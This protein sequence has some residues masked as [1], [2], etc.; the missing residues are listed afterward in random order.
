MGKDYPLGMGR[1]SLGVNWVLHNG[2]A[3][4]P[5]RV[6]LNPPYSHPLIEQFA[7]KLLAQIDAGYVSEAMVLVNNNTETAWWHNLADRADLLFA[8]R[9]RVFFH[10][11]GQA[12]STSP[13]QGQ[14]L[15]YF[16][17]NTAAFHD[18]FAAKGIVFSRF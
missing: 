3:M 8:F 18:I 4:K 12:E 5:A 10:R 2:P 14:T 16:G 15:F 13:R 9:S 17:P 6:W 11:P 7:D 1:G